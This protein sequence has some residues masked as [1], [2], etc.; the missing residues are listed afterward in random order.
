MSFLT[1][2]YQWSGHPE[3]YD[4]EHSIKFF[5]SGY[6]EFAA[7]GGQAFSMICGGD[8][9]TSPNTTVIVKPSRKRNAIIEE[10]QVSF[11]YGLVDEDEKS[12]KHRYMPDLD[13]LSQ[14]KPGIQYRI[15]RGPFFLP[16]SYRSENTQIFLYRL[17]LDHYPFPTPDD[18]RLTLFDL[19]STP[20]AFDQP[21]VYYA[22]GGIRNE[23]FADKQLLMTLNAKLESSAKQIRE[24]ERQHDYLEDTLE[25]SSCWATHSY[26]A[27]L[28]HVKH[29]PNLA[30]QSIDI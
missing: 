14:R 22:T 8:W 2:C 4:Y 24:F 15:R 5:P 10:G 25:T 20:M 17:E 28:K 6:V 12:F 11:C 1:R 30:L 13:L 19:I 26:R 7:G 9:W 23:D 18:R 21:L 3:W 27:W 16:G 29:D